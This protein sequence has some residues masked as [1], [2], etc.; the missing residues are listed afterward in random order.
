MST[1]A[2]TFEPKMNQSHGPCELFIIFSRYNYFIILVSLLLEINVDFH[3]ETMKL[4][5]RE[6]RED[7]I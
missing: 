4:L 2:K 6:H 7:H 3:R 5:H 1:R